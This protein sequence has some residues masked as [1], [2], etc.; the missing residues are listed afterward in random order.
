M[1]VAPGVLGSQVTSTMPVPVDT[2]AKTYSNA[3][4]AAAIKNSGLTE[5][6]VRARLEAAGFDPKFADPFFQGGVAGSLAT[7]ADPKSVVDPSFANMLSALGILDTLAI[8]SSRGAEA[9]TTESHG[10][11]GPFPPSRVGPNSPFGKAFFSSATSAFDAVS[12]GPVDASYRLGI[13]DQVQLVIT[14]EMEAAFALDIRRDGTILVPQIGQIPIAGLTLESARA[15]I[16]QR[17]ARVYSVIGEG[18][19]R[20][21]LTV[22]RV[23]TNQVFVVGEV[24]RPGSYL[25]NALGTVF[26]ALNAAGGPTDRG[27]FRNIAVRR[28]GTVATRVDLYDYLLRGDASNDIRTEQGDIVFVGLSTRLVTLKGAVRRPGIYELKDA[29]KID[30]LLEFGGGALPSA[31]M[32]RLL[33]DRILPPAQRTPGKERALIDVPLTGRTAILDS[34]SLYD[35]DV[36]TIFSVGNLRRNRVVLTGEVFEPGVYEWTPDLTL[37]QL[38][39]KA[40]GFLPW[41]LTDRIKIERQILHTGRSE[42]LSASMRDSSLGKV[43]LQEFD[44]VTV[45]DARRAFPTGTIAISGAVV[46]PGQRAYA[47]NL[48]LKDF[49]DLSG[50]FK[51]EAAVVELARRKFSS[52]YSDTAAVITSYPIE[53]GGRLSSEAASVVLEREDRVNVRDFPGY[54]SVPRAV[55]LAGLFTY[56]GTY[57]LRSDAEKVSDVVRRASGLLPSA[58]PPGARLIRDGRPVAIDLGKALKRDRDND[59]YLSQ[60]DRLEIGPDPSVVYVS[61]AVERQVI[62]PF[63]PGWGVKDYVMAAGGF[64]DD[65]EKGNVV[66]EYPSGEIRSR[67]NRFFM[68]PASDMPVISGSTITVGRKLDNKGANVGETLTRT[69]QVVST[70]M[71]LLIGYLAVRR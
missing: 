3:E 44:T 8:N 1:L 29:E 22:S 4:I 56:P 15:N 49:V 34:L 27:T 36:V 48:T 38:V 59:I 9:D 18:R 60:G 40:Q 42:F 50:G 70:L 52:R 61:G 28:G 71:S 58:Y 37:D 55:T 68:L 45:L 19:A 5:A 23:R 64:S 53:P 69:V 51:P 16:R 6:Q 24:E 13:G 39:N 54:R 31:A 46:N 32:D 21:D 43:V 11:R 10:S 12:G 67:T 26:R 2:T 14:G 47:E 66:V 35:G 7:S 41:A 17:A 65:A 57:V 30:R 25:V 62:V 33:I 20:V 63:H